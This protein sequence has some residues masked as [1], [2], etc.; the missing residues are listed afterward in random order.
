MDKQTT[1][2]R[3]GR[4]RLRAGRTLGAVEHRGRSYRLVEVETETG[5]GYLSLR[6]YNAR[7]KFLKQLLFE[8]EL[9][10]SLS[11]LLREEGTDGITAGDP[12]RQG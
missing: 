11:E 10:G 1:G 8:L 3:F 9:R 7:G 6:L 2:F 5:Q 12:E 4:H